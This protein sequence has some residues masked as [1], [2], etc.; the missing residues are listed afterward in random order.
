MY[1]MLD[2]PSLPMC[3]YN[4]SSVRVRLNQKAYVIYIYYIQYG[5]I[6]VLEF[7]FYP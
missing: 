3:H 2:S 6:A 1:F 4:D 5:M 7:N